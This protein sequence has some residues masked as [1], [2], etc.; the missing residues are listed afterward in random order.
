MNTQI[1]RDRL[2]I[3]DPMHK[4]PLSKVQVNAIVQQ[5]L[6]TIEQPIKEHPS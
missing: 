3:G 6:E 5:I 2:G 1:P 4:E